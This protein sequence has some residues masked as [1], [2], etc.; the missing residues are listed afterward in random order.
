MCKVRIVNRMAYSAYPKYS[1]SQSSN[2]NSSTPNPST[3]AGTGSGG[4]FISDPYGNLIKVGAGSG[5]AVGGRDTTR[6]GGG[7]GGSKTATS[8]ISG[9]KVTKQQAE[10]E[11]R[12]IEIG[13]KQ[14]QRRR[15]SQKL[16][17]ITRVTTDP[18]TGEVT[19]HSI[20]GEKYTFP[21]ETQVTYTGREKFG[22]VQ[23]RE[24]IVFVE[25]KGEV[26]AYAPEQ[27]E[28][29]YIAEA[30]TRAEETFKKIPK[31]PIYY[32]GRIPER[33]TEVLKYEQ[34]TQE[35]KEILMPEPPLMMEGL[36]VRKVK[37]TRYEDT[38]SEYARSRYLQ[39]K[40][41]GEA[42]LE[43]K[44]AQRFLRRIA[45]PV[46]GVGKVLYAP[47][48][49][50]DTKPKIDIGQE[51]YL[52][53]ER[54]LIYDP[55][56]QVV[57]VAGATAFALSLTP[58]VVAATVGIGA[59]AYTGTKA[60]VSRRTPESLADFV[61]T[62]PAGMM[63]TRRIAAKFNKPKITAELG[64]KVYTAREDVG[65]VSKMRAAYEIMIG[66]KKY[67]VQVPK[68]IEYGG[69]ITKSVQHTR[70]AYEFYSKDYR[71]IQ[72]TTGLTVRRGDITSSI[73]TYKM[74]VVNSFARG[75]KVDA[76]FG[77]SR[78]VTEPYVF[79]ELM[80]YRQITHTE[81]LKVRHPKLYGIDISKQ[82]I[83]TRTKLAGQLTIRPKDVMFDYFKKPRGKSSVQVGFI[84]E[85]LKVDN[86]VVSE[87][88]LR[89]IYGKQARKFVNQIV[90]GQ[91]YRFTV[92]KVQTNLGVSDTIGKMFSSKRAGLISETELEIQQPSITAKVRV[93]A[94]QFAKQ[95]YQR[96]FKPFSYITPT[97]F[98]K[99]SKNMLLDFQTDERTF[100][101]VTNTSLMVS[102]T[103]RIRQR[104]GLRMGL[105]LSLDMGQ[106][107]IS[108]IRLST[109][110][111]QA[112]QQTLISL[113]GAEPYT[114]TPPKQ[115]PIPPGIPPQFPPPITF[116]GIERKRKMR[117]LQA[118]RLRMR[119]QPSLVP[120][121]QK[122][123]GKRPKILTGLRI[124]PVVI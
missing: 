122:L 13:I 25:E 46:I 63:G 17:V 88:K 8:P 83:L 62:M 20:K 116:P 37:E 10:Q 111:A 31:E 58:A 92:P 44:A 57:A 119:Y 36:G 80:R 4:T 55:D 79:D 100:Y 82:P 84:K 42:Q 38:L 45:S 5:T 35:Q 9:E 66:E 85:T 50:K 96:E 124:R 81:L 107:Y 70:G 75:M 108:R 27:F 77:R 11:Q 87:A 30:E 112:Q 23:T 105:L 15:A 103:S 47:N 61:L 99:A 53:T 26:K 91:Q 33:G 72:T 28:R 52:K 71:A 95:I 69:D 60:F 3:A 101:P 6:S 40:S 117:Q 7:G 118:F 109:R 14:E 12:Q 16:G 97:D 106:R 21:S 64:T 24:T 73:D 90:K 113:I 89:S 67:V 49:M 41:I 1:G 120:I 78:T 98:S 102:Q 68:A 94:E 51:K 19:Y 2:S 93:G 18:N 54:G 32:T 86:I 110:Q 74:F 22:G 65:Q 56:V 76:L 59:T 123:V 48:W 114:P 115:P 121:A 104:V 29:R 39:Y 34:L 43:N